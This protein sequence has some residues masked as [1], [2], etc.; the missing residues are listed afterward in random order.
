MT[1]RRAAPPR[2]RREG[3]VAVMWRHVA[4]CGD[5]RDTRRAPQAASARARSRRGGAGGADGDAPPLR[6]ARSGEESDDAVAVRQATRRMTR[7]RRASGEEADDGRGA[8]GEEADDGRGAVA[9]GDLARALGLVEP[10]GASCGVMWCHAVIWRVPSDWSSHLVVCHVVS[11]GRE[12]WAECV[13]S[14]Q[15]LGS[16]NHSEATDRRTNAVRCPRID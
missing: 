8:S 1:R 12:R 6:Y 2:R 9:R 7:S 3:R 10:P 16:P 14:C 15:D 5:E 13:V 4:S 11:C